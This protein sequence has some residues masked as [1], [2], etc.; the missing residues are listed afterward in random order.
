MSTEN[1]SIRVPAPIV[2]KSQGYDME[3]SIVRK[4]TQQ[5][6]NLMKYIFLC[7]LLIGAVEYFKFSTQVHY[8]WFHCT[9]IKEPISGSAIKLWARG[10]PSCDK[11]G[12]M[13]TIMKRI[14]RDFEPNDEAVAFCL[15]E[16]NN[17]PAR[18]YPV[19]EDKGKPGYYA[20]VGY[21]SDLSTIESHC[22]G[23]TIYNF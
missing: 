18:H 12:E 17:I 7:F 20:I 4:R 2:T 15:I 21:Q 5:I 22:K 1:K 19:G 13:K 10:G 14:T 11:R 8:E 16:E 6:K 9:P 3:H 23:S